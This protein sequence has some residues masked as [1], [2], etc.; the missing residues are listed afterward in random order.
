MT[1]LGLAAS[2]ARIPDTGPLAG[3]IHGL[4]VAAVAIVANALLTMQRRLAPDLPRAR[5]SRPRPR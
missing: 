4:E 1:V 5:C 2:Q 3:A